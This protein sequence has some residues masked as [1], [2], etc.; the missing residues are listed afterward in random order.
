MATLPPPYQ[1]PAARRYPA[2]HGSPARH[3]GHPGSGVHRSPQRRGSRRGGRV[4]FSVE[5]I[6]LNLSLQDL[7]YSFEKVGRENNIKNQIII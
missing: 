3:P 5:M 1:R 7:L 2:P 4:E 6:G